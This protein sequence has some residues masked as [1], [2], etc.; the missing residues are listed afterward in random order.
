MITSYCAVSI[1]IAFIVFVVNGLTGDADVYL[2]GSNVFV[3]DENDGSKII[4]TELQAVST[5]TVYILSAEYAGGNLVV[6]VNNAQVLSV[7]VNDT[8][9]SVRSG[10][11]KCGCKI[12]FIEYQTADVISGWS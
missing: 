1:L 8:Q 12:W 5:N 10:Y 7:G 2:D 11:D 3:T 6:K 9:Q 4:A